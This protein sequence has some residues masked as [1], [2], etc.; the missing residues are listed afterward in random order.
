[1]TGKKP[2]GALFISE[3]IVVQNNNLVK[4][5]I[6][7]KNHFDWVFFSDFFFSHWYWSTFDHY[8]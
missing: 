6:I 4:L 7:H 5:H 3:T 2:N 8:I 1:M